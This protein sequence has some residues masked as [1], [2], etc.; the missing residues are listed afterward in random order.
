MPNL[1]EQN[2]ARIQKNLN[3]LRANG[4]TADEQR[5]YMEFEA[6]KAAAPTH[7]TMPIIPAQ[8]PQM[9]TPQK[10][11]M[12]RLKGEAPALVGGTIGAFAGGPLGAMAGAGAGKGYQMMAQYGQEAL[13]G[14]DDLQRQLLHDPRTASK[15]IGGEMALAG[16]GEAVGIP[17]AKVA[18]KVAAPFAKTVIPEAVEVSEELAKFGGKLTPAQM[19]EAAPLDIIEN[20][21]RSAPFGKDV[22][23]RQ[24]LQGKDAWARWGQSLAGEMGEHASDPEVG[25]LVL[26][27]GKK[28]IDAHR[29]MGQRLYVDA[30]KKFSQEPIVSVAPLREAASKH[31]AVFAETAEVGKTAK[32]AGLLRKVAKVGEGKADNV[33]FENA[34]TLRSELLGLQRDMAETVG[35]GKTKRIIGD[36]ITA[37]DDSM[38]EAA[39]KQG[40]GALASWR[41]ANRFWKYGKE[42]F[43]NNFMAGLIVK[44][45]K[46]PERI[47]EAIFRSGNVDEII[48]FKKALRVAANLDKSI[49][50]NAVWGK[51]QRN[52]LESILAKKTSAKTAEI[53]PDTVLKLFTD[54]KQSRTLREIYTAEQVKGI[55]E[56]ARAGQLMNKQMG[57]G[58]MVMQLV[59][60]TALLALAT[61]QYQ[62]GAAT[63]FIAPY[64]LARM[65]TNP[66]TA[67]LLTVGYTIPVNTPKGIGIAGR[68]MAEAAKIDLEMQRERHDARKVA[69]KKEPRKPTIHEMV[70][71][72]SGGRNEQVPA[73][74]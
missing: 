18:Q 61:G 11:F 74:P 13:E 51:M 5:R 8:R 30:A 3:Y 12:E 60:G 2:T 40:G 15:A 50:H 7:G 62:K 68:I 64:V 20:M 41:K 54:P 27:M 52:H 70:W 28:G 38:Q 10:S 55:T 31:L 6:N 69:A 63:V 19:T 47:S 22:L 17:I 35:E 65:L 48:K 49:D 37:L 34:I 32:S 66:V 14:K 26:D 29:I 39:E 24:I 21:V 71:R 42:T 53:N 73:T 56:W 44:N 1:Q 45:K 43:E 4:A 25:Q 23:E 57:G 36:L 33:T 9:P 16:T 67:K 46:T 72:A 58:G 59:Q